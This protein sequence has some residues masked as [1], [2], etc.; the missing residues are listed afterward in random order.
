MQIALSLLVLAAYASSPQPDETRHEAPEQT[1]PPNIILIVADDLG[2]KELG[3]YGQTKIRTP[4][5]DRIAAEGIRF[6]QFYSGSPVC[7]PSR[8]ALLTG[9]HTGHS[10]IRDN[11]EM[12]GWERDATEG[13]LPIPDGTATIGRVLQAAG[14][15][16]AVIGKWGL[17]GPGSSGEPNNQGF[18]HWYG[19]LCQR[20][21]HNYYPTHLW[22]NGR[23]QILNNEW[24]PAHQRLEGDPLDPKSYEKYQGN[25]YAPDLMAEEAIDFIRANRD[26]PFFLYYA[27]IVP[28]VSLQVPADS[29]KEYVGAF[30]ETPYVGD[31][32]YLPHP[33]PR[34]AY[35]AMITRMDRRVGEM[36]SLLKE[37]GLDED[38]IIIFTSD[39]GPSWV[40]G[41]DLD[42]FRGAGPF[43]GRK[44][45]LYEGGIRV[46][47]VVRWPDK[48]RP[49]TV[50]YHLSA[51]WDLMPTIAEIAGAKA[52][53]NVDGISL[54]PTLLA[55]GRQRHHD[56]LYWEYHAGDGHQAV[57]MGRWKGV[58]IGGKK[59]PNAPIQ[60][61][62]LSDDI[63][64]SI[65][66]SARFPDIVAK[67]EA[68]MDRRTASHLDRWNFAKKSDAPIHERGFNLAPCTGR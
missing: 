11:Y 42:F 49:G 68:V 67:I 10:Y 18:D 56:N 5:I 16:T 23:K 61:Y 59:D 48:I 57:R 43:R 20:V 8:C 60:L 62:N 63:A 14:Y 9:M 30:P 19:Y 2:Y 32:G 66:V 35:A 39:N 4:N 34:A 29:L 24:F 65:D 7:A 17:G 27:P 41:A 13:Q 22:R 26:K 37:L 55:K 31:K 21:A 47:M 28:H 1:N 25:L 12:G 46:P 15:T 40:G 36:L 58:R 45:T 6:M 52:P 54:I 38:T 50:T 3:C 44:A 64:E 51:F 53:E 33:T